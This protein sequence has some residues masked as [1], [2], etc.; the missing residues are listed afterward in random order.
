VPIDRL[1]K[2]ARAKVL[3]E[4]EAI[5]L[6]DLIARSKG[7]VSEAARDSKIHRSYLIQMLKRHGLK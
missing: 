5:F 1:L 6:A 2:D 4:F 3:D 7:N